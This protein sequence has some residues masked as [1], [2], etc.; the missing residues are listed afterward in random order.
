M[1]LRSL[2]AGD[3]ATRL[4]IARQRLVQRVQQKEPISAV[5]T[6]VLGGS[7][8]S[9]REF[10]PPLR[11]ESPAAARSAGCRESIRP[12]SRCKCRGLVDTSDGT[13]VANC[14]DRKQR[15]PL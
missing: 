3:G 11:G 6:S 15:A 14:M 2:F 5:R 9:N 4:P 7:G 1:V 12:D 10:F 8:E 13:S